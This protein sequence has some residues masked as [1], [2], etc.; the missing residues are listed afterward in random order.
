[1]SKE[2]IFPIDL[3]S[4]KNFGVEKWYDNFSPWPISEE[5][6]HEIYYSLEKVYKN[7]INS[8]SK[9]IADVFIVLFKLIKV[10]YSY[11]YCQI[12]ISRITKEGYKIFYDNSGKYYFK[13]L[14]E[15]Q[16][17]V[18]FSTFIDVRPN[19]INNLKNVFLSNARNIKYKLKQNNFSFI[20]KKGQLICFENPKPVLLEYAF[21]KNKKIHMFPYSSFIAKKYRCKLD[22][23]GLIEDILENIVQ[24]SKDHGLKL[25]KSQIIYLKIASEKSLNN[26]Y[27][28]IEFYKHY[29]K[30]IHSTKILIPNFGNLYVRA[31]CVA[32]KRV[33]HQVIGSTHGNNVGFYKRSQWYYS[34]MILCDEYIV[35]TSKSV[36]AFKKYEESFGIKKKCKLKLSTRSNNPYRNIFTTLNQDELAS[37]NK[38]VMIMEY[39]HSP[40]FLPLPFQTSYFQ[41]WLVIKISQLLKQN[42]FKTIIKLH[43]D[44]L[45]ESN[46]LYNIY[47]D[48]IISE[49]FEVSYKQ[50]DA[51]IF[52]ELSTTCLPFSLLT[53][54]TLFAFRY[55]ANTFIAKSAINNFSKRVN[56][57]SSEFSDY[58]EFIFDEEFIINKLKEKPKIPNYSIIDQYYFDLNKFQK[59]NN[60]L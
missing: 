41:L 47:F 52:P 33:G 18:P 15:E 19:L 14:I 45:F 26:A 25:R 21:Q 9:E 13:G 12:S 27:E 24:I 2:K 58:G 28:L 34:D 46:N 49:K 22:F 3:W 57:I 16:S 44:R 59:I 40:D 5:E 20:Y 53:K 8:Q 31:L 48:K 38:T 35:P 55:G 6:K 51:I 43:P 4:I 7:L 36:D 11:L 23:Q 10:Y 50:A 30:K 56:L 42:G 39:P 1:M 54:K 32:A 60:T 29:L 17:F 37:E